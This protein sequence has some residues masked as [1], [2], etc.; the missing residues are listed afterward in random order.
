MAVTSTALSEDTPIIEALR[1]A[2]QIEPMVP[3]CREWLEA[4]LTGTNHSGNL[5]RVPQPTLS[6]YWDATDRQFCGKPKFGRTLLVTHFAGRRST[7]PVS[8]EDLDDAAKLLAERVWK[9][10]NRK[11]MDLIKVHDMGEDARVLDNQIHTSLDYI[12]G[13]ILPT[14]LEMT[15]NLDIHD[16]IVRCALKI[17]AD[18]SRQ[19]AGQ[20][21]RLQQP[22]DLKI[23]AYNSR[24]RALLTHPWVQ[25]QIQAYYQAMLD[26]LREDVSRFVD[27][28]TAR[29]LYPLVDRFGKERIA[30]ALLKSNVGFSFGGVRHGVSKA[31][32]GHYSED[33]IAR[34]RFVEVVILVSAIVGGTENRVVDQ[35][36][37]YKPLQDWLRARP[38]LCEFWAEHLDTADYFEM[39]LR[40][41]P[42]LF[43]GRAILW[44][45]HYRS[46]SMEALISLMKKPPADFDPA[47]VTI[48]IAGA[49]TQSLARGGFGLDLYGLL[50]A[51]DINGAKI[52]MSGFAYDIW[53]AMV[54]HGLLSDAV[55]AMNLKIKERVTIVTTTVIE[56]FKDKWI[57]ATDNLQG[58]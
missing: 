30:K 45:G 42:W 43:H 5:V 57:V 16:A 28:Y 49:T 2:S 46:Q 44:E 18:N 3:V 50:G 20:V 4:S 8:V 25:Q 35:M 21:R 58:L 29:D 11:R 13:T 26:M 55:S 54:K 6:I 51:L 52:L 40:V 27:L 22:S 31:A 10:I 7:G 39:A 47:Q 12:T 48:V 19:R 36:R 32:L 33:K 14:T 37:D 15:G 9:A 53:L 34:G 1:A 56:S 38:E 24:Q 17:E 23:E 41:A